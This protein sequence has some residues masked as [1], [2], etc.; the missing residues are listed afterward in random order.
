MDDIT[1]EASLLDSSVDGR[2]TF[3]DMNSLNTTPAMKQYLELK[4]EYSEYLLFYRMGDFYELF[5]E[6]AITASGALGLT[7]TSRSKASGKEIPMCGVPFHA[8]ELYL[9][10]LIKMGYK[11]AVCEQMENPKDAKKRGYKEVV[12][13]DVVRLVTPGTLT[14]E[15]LLDAKSNNYIISSYVRSS[16]IGLAWLDISTGAFFTQSLKVDKIPAHIMLSNA[17]A[18]L[19]PVELLIEDRLLEYPKFFEL[20]GEYRDKLSVRAKALFNFESASNTLRQ[21]YHL[22]FETLDIFGDLSKAEVIAAGVL[23]EYVEATQKGKLPRIEKPRRVFSENLMEIDAATRRSLELFSSTNSGGMSLLKAIDRTVTGIG[24]RLLAERLASPIMDIKEINNRLDCISFFVDNPQVRRE[25][26]EAMRKCQ[27]MERAVQRLSIGRGG[28]RDLF[29]LAV[30]LRLIPRIQNAILQFTNFQSDSMYALAPQSL[31][32]LAESF[33]DHSSLEVDI[34]RSLLS[35]RDDLPVLVRNGE[36]I[37]DGAYASLDYMRNIRKES[38]LKCEELQQKYT[39]ETGINGLKIKNNS[40]I[41]YFVEVPAK[42]AGKLL[43]NAR[44][45]HRQSVLNAVR[46]T[47]QEL[48]ELENEVNTSQEKALELEQSIF[49]ELTERVLG[50]ADAISHSATVIAAF[51]VA[52]GLAEL[53]VERNYTRP[54]IN[55]TLDFEVIDGR[56]PVVEAVMKKDGKGDFIGNNCVLN[57]KNDRIWL[58]TGPNMAGKS[59]FLRQNALIT[60]L[61]Q[62]G[63]FVPAQ[64]AK[65]GLID[66][67]FSRV[68]ASDDLARGRS[69]FMVEMVETATILNRAGTRSFV[70]LDEIGRGTA[71][72]DGLSIAWAVVEQLSEVNRCRTIFATHYHELTKLNKHLDGLSLHCMKIKEYNEDIVFLHQVLE[73]AADRSYGIHVAKLA[74][75]PNITVQRAEQVLHLLEEEKQHKI[76]NAVEDELPL[77]ET[78]KIRETKVQESEVEKVIKGLDIDEMTPREAL[79]KLYELKEKIN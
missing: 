39:D 70:I 24:G 73:G 56:H 20:F 6:D 28:P 9:A 12:Q 44:F 18:R 77:F 37:R 74:G 43:D 72:F 13:R 78:L 53:A 50:Q 38:E 5:F 63:S 11:V 79:N 60:I 22:K 59:T 14:E 75:L 34:S 29:D 1:Q 69:T 19:N 40:V 35:K 30:S 51:D 25:I 55:D 23:L 62:M 45:I 67:L 58:L 42:S 68:G 31:R 49:T 8:Y 52:A 57:A 36:F 10:R 71:T 32:E 41:G 27:D 33:Y 76:L 7:L 15:S 47:T 3:K 26:R 4:K 66:K 64:S 54:V 48:S 61:A 2:V 21:V 46:F 17:L 16:E 65:I